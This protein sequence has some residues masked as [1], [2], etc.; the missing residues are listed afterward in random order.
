MITHS[1][2][3]NRITPPKSNERRTAE[4]TDCCLILMF[5]TKP[6][7]RLSVHHILTLTS[8]LPPIVQMSKQVKRAMET[9]GGHPGSDSGLYSGLRPSPS[10]PNPE[11]QSQG[12]SRQAASHF[13]S[14]W[15][16]PAHII[17][18]TWGWESHLK[19]WHSCI[20]KTNL[21]PS[22]GGHLPLGLGAWQGGPQSTLVSLP[23]ELA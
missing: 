15:T 4:Q 10:P 16:N 12:Y 17:P 22:L 23:L 14:P 13:L 20:A 21:G 8:T 19:A 5:C 7:A 18:G 6:C 2:C 3:I 11:K 9:D 1:I